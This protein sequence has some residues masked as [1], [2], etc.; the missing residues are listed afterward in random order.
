MTKVL[1]VITGADRWTLN[2]GTVHPSGY[3]AEEVAMPYK[4]FTEAGFDITVATPG[5][6]KPTLDHLSLSLAGGSAPWKVGKI[7]KY[8]KSIDDKLS[9][10]KVLADMN[11]D[12]YDLVFYPGGHGPM[13]D[14]AYD[15]DSGKLLTK[16]L[17]SGR[18]LA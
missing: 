6:E 13:E 15:K 11:A 14:L 16:R 9:K 18:P 10:P 3:W 7:K 17:V 8:L 5:G 12:D 2:D 4:I 1:F